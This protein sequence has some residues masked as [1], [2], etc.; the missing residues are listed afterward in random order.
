MQIRSMRDF[1]KLESSSGILLFSAAVLALV[2]DNSPL[3]PIYNLL[4]STPLSFRLGNLVVGKPLVMWINEGLMAMFFLLVGLEVKREMLVGELNS[5]RKAVLPVVAAIGGMI[6]PALV[7][8]YLNWHNPVALRGWAIPTATDLAFALGILALLGSRVP[9]SLKIFLTAFAI[10][11]DIGGISIIAGY[12]SHDIAYSMLLLS[13]GLIVLL[14]ILNRFNITARAPYFLVGGV[15]W[16]C[17]LKSGIHATLTGVI[18]ALMI[19]VSDRKNPQVSPLR[20][21]EDALHPWVAY[22]I[23]PVFAFANAGMSF[24]GFSW[25]DM[26]KPI[27]LGIAAGL[28]FGK[29]IGI[30]LFSWLVL[31]LGIAQ[32]PHGAT[33]LGLYGIA[34]IGG[35]GFTMSLFIGGLAFDPSNAQYSA[36]VRMGVLGGSLIS[37]LVGYILLRI[38]YRRPRH[39][40]MPK[41]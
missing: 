29:Q 34:M 14:I 36:Y 35:V 2:I 6:V 8:A 33:W 10:F 24:A 13:L 5:L 22:M 4:L 15:L 25:S 19:P 18:L 17:V 38:A 40:L 41:Q 7:Y 30:W 31:S 32:K 20:D 21:L 9:V 37:G 28:F 1:L 11:D 16:L 39:M 23:L 26:L 27:P 3:A 12:Y